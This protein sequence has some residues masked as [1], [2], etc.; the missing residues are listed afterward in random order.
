MNELHEI[1]LEVEHLSKNYRLEHNRE[2]FTALND[3]S[4]TV[5]KGDVIGIIG[6]NGSGKSTL[7]KILSNIT[8]PSTGMAKFYGSV[9]SILDVGTNFH[10]DL[11]GRENVALLLQ[12]NGVERI[13][14][15]TVEK[16]VY[17]FSEIGDFFDQPVKVYSSG[18]FLRLAFA[19]AFHLHADI[20]LL[21]EVLSVGDEGF[22]LKCQDMLKQLATSGKTILFV[23]HNRLE[24]LE[25]AHKCI[26]LNKGKV[27]RTG[28][29]ATILSE[30]FALHRD[31]YDEKK[32]IADTHQPE[33]EHTNQADGIIDITWSEHNAPGNNVFCIR[34]LTVKPGQEGIEKLLQNA[35]VSIS[36]L[37][38]KKQEGNQI[39]AFFFLQDVFYQPVLVGHFLN[40]HSS[41]NFGKALQNQ[42][43]FF[44]ISCTI[45]ANFL[46]PGKYYLLPRFGME[47]EEWNIQS[48]EVFRFSEKL[49][50]T[51]YASNNYVDL[52]GDIS[53]GSVRPMLNWDVRKV[54]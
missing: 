21:D 18:M 13:F 44:E 6:N 29:A 28:N 12:L 26:W 7:L 5:N 9:V 45:P 52:I 25:L 31:N 40:N 35:P 27:M 23:S 38:E 30:Y 36:F 19:L 43:G 51:I 42:T 33:A 37:I 41:S 16:Q 32:Q 49:H 2:S 17:E 14:F 1:V 53:K 46:A 54:N 11:T 3:V 20:L 34:R 50:F 24:I 22:R 48:E 4:F 15:G 8:K 47:K 10:P 39:G